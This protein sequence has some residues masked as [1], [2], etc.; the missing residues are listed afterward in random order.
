MVSPRF[1]VDK[2]MGS[3]LEHLAKTPD[4]QT[5][6]DARA[7][8]TQSAQAEL[9][10][11]KST[12]PGPSAKPEPDAKPDPS[13][14]PEQKAKPEQSAKP[15]HT[16]HLVRDLEI[17]GIAIAATGL[18]V[19]G[20]KYKPLGS[21]AESVLKFGGEDS[22]ALAK[23]IPKYPELSIGD[24]VTKTTENLNQGCV[25]RETF[26]RLVGTVAPAD[27]P[28]AGS[29][30]KLSLPNASDFTL[31]HGLR[32]MGKQLETSGVNLHEL[33]ELTSA[34]P[35]SPGQT[36]AY[37]FR[38]ANGIKLGIHNLGAVDAP[39]SGAITSKT[40]I[41][42]FDHISEFSSEQLEQ[43]QKAAQSGRQIFLMDANN[44][45]SGINFTDFA[46]GTAESKLQTLVE[47]AKTLA[48]KA[49]EITPD[50]ATPNVVASAAAHS[51]EE[52]RLAYRLLN[53]KTDTD[54]T[55]IGATVIRPA[56]VSDDN[57]FRQIV[58]KDKVESY[59]AR[60]QNPAQQRL[61]A[62][63]LADIDYESFSGI[64]KQ[65]QKLHQA[66]SADAIASGL[67]PTKDIRYLV[68]VDNW[69]NLGASSGGFISS[70]YREMNGLE[71]Q[72]FVDFDRMY[73]R[74]AAGSAARRTYVLDDMSH[75]GEQIRSVATDL[76]REYGVGGLT[77]TT[78]SALKSST[79]MKYA[80]ENN[81]TG[82]LR[83]LSADLKDPIAESSRATIKALK[84]E[85]GFFQ[86]PSNDLLQAQARRQVWL[87]MTKGTVG[88]KDLVANQLNPYVVSDR[89]NPITADF[90]KQV[91]NMQQ[92]GFSKI[93]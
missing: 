69:P 93:E 80:I 56:A 36:T 26:D 50:V 49:P 5:P 40:P 71:P 27:R 53:G 87:D 3:E 52:E 22:G 11:A 41:L 12:K 16:S 24:L 55:A 1:F 68:G 60:F 42:L 6:P 75:S 18:V 13:A 67:D 20:F 32:D 7:K 82:G 28:L 46:K 59:L 86:A 14:K 73:F 88:R 47:Q 63:T 37:L 45:H 51:T 44:F 62:E 29:I 74:S 35:A 2:F 78:N 4:G 90:A 25:S 19:A 83:F 65:T 33:Q 79:V 9:S 91:L 15:E 48:G 54:A 64:A 76:R 61:A 92:W 84:A 10:K 38:K 8:L 70:I 34:N 58:N 17:A 30:A 66:I 57:L 21:L 23:L 43:L 85:K 39:T 77:F 72:R 81:P 89:T 31:M